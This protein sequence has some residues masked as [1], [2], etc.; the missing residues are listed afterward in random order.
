MKTLSK[1]L[2]VL[3]VCTLLLSG[4]KKDEEVPD[5]RESFVGNYAVKETSPT[6]GESDY[7]IT[8]SKSADGSNIEI[9]N[10]AGLLKKKVQATVNGKT[11]TIPTQTFTSGN[12]Q[13][14]ISGTG[15]LNGNTLSYSYATRGGFTWDATCVSTRK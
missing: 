10:F 9:A 14:T 3:S 15:T 6:I 12:V 4:C 8:I 7:S 1:C 2:F 11:I 13:I 5:L